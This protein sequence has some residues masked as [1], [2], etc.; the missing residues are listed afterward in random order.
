MVQDMLSQTPL[1]PQVEYQLI[2]NHLISDIQLA[3]LDVF[4]GECLE[5]VCLFIINRFIDSL[6]QDSQRFTFKQ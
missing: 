1:W 5:I 6:M 2:L 3:I 4:K